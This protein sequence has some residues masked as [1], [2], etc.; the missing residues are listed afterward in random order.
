MLSIPIASD[1][2]GF[3]L[4]KR[5]IDHFDDKIKFID[6]GTYDDESVDYP[7][8]AIK[9]VEYITRGEASMGILI[10]GSGN[11]MSIFANKFSEIRC[12]LAWNRE[13]ARLARLHNDAN[14]LA[15]PG[16]FIEPEEAFECVKAFINTPFEGERH[17]KRID[18]INLYIKNF[19]HNGDNF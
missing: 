13:L 8:F 10:C 14:V 15:L 17:Q 12:A 3:H 6:L 1:H 2:A 9:V 18:K 5:I 11:G 16:R 7:D 4:K 19:H